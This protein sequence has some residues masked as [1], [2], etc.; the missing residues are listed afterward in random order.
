MKTLFILILFILACPSDIKT[1]E[2]SLYIGLR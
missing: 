1:T 2:V